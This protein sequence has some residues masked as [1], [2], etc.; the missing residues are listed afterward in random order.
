MQSIVSLY[1]VQ[2]AFSVKLL[3]DGLLRISGV[4]INCKKRCQEKN[5]SDFARTTDVVLEL[6]TM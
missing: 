4:F 5:M 1:T 6:S 3:I 2:Q